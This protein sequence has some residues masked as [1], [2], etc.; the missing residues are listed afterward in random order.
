MPEEEIDW[1][2][3]FLAPAGSV[4]RKIAV[5]AAIDGRGDR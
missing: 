5:E 2:Q 4:S 1:N 3:F